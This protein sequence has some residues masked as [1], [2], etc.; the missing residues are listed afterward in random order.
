MA[1]TWRTRSTE[2]VWV[3]VGLLGLGASLWLAAGTAIGQKADVPAAARYQ[4]RY[5]PQGELL[6]PEGFEEWVF[7]GSNLG[8]EYKEGSAEAQDQTEPPAGDLRNF[9]N[10]YIDPAA[11]AEFRRTGQFPDPTTL[12]LDI[13]K[14]RK[15]EAGSFVSAGLFPADRQGVAVAVKH[16]GRADGGK[17][18]WAYYDF[19][20]RAKTAKAFADK[21]C[22]DCHLEH[23]TVDNVFVQ[24]Y[25]VLK[26]SQPGARPP[27][28]KN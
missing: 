9:H 27:A 13:Y 7:V 19:A 5:S 15:G 21:A 25:P 12:V 1:M 28:G 2:A 23:G 6:Y 14:A 4:P 3:A 26:A 16:A 10:V 18:N 8:L 17:S 20:P 22:Y 11:Y 24:F